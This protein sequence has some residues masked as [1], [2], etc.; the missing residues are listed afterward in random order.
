MEEGDVRLETGIDLEGGRVG[1]TPET[2]G[3]PVWVSWKGL[4]CGPW[5]SW[6]PWTGGLGGF[7]VGG[8]MGW[9]WECSCV[10]AVPAADADRALVACRPGT[11]GLAL[12]DMIGLG[13]AWTLFIPLLGCFSR[14]GLR[15]IVKIS[16]YQANTGNVALR[17]SL[18]HQ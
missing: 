7:L 6:S 9:D 14:L 17:A 15:N 11:G 8:G 10:R 3:D 5:F 4:T 2:V 12:T 13:K 18:A 16:P 1:F